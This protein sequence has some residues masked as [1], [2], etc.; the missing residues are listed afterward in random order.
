MFT[1]EG[2]LMDKKRTVIIILFVAIIGILAGIVLWRGFYKN[3]D[4]KYMESANE[5]AVTRYEWMKML[6][7][8][9]G[10][11]EYK[12][13]T[14][15]FSDVN[16]DSVYFPYLQSAVEWGILEIAID[17]D[18][19]NYAS[20]Q[21]AALTAMKTIGHRKLQIYLDTEDVITDDTYIEQAVIHGLIE[22]EQ[23]VEGLSIGECEQILENFKILYFSEFWRDDYTNVQY[24][25]G[26]IELYPGDVLQS[27]ADCSEIVIADKVVNSL[28]VGTIIV[29]EQHNTKLKLARK[30]T[31]IDTDGVLSLIP[32]ELDKVVE[33]ITVSDITELTFE[34]ILNYYGLGENI[35]TV[36]SLKYQQAG[37]G[38]INTAI[39]S[40]E[41]N[42][43]GYK[44]SLSTKGAGKDK[45]LEVQ[46]TDHAT[47]VSVTL[48]ISDK[49]ESDNEYSADVD[50]DRICIGGQVEY[51]LWNGLEYAETAVDAHATFEGMVK[52]D[53]DK[54]I[55][56][57]KTPVPIGNGIVAADIQIY[58][59]LSI[60]GSISFEAELPVEFSIYYEKDKGLR[61]LKHDISIENPTIE[62]NCDLGVMLRLEPTLIILDC[63][64][65]MDIEA[66][67]G[68]TA[69]ANVA[70]H[71]NSQIC[72]DISV[73]FPVITLYVCG[74]DDVDTIIGDM[75]L[76]AEWEIIS[77]ADTPIQLGLHYE[78]LS[79]KTT[80]FV[81]KCT[82]NES[83]ESEEAT[84]EDVA[85]KSTFNNTYYTQ[86]GKV[87]QIDGLVFC[88]DYPNNWNVTHEEVVNIDEEVTYMDYFGEIVELTNNR[89]V[90][91]TYTQ[92][93]M[94][95]SV[96]GN[97]SAFRYTVEYDITKV[98]DSNLKSLN[99]AE[100]EDSDSFMVA[101][102]REYGGTDSNGT[103]TDRDIVSYAVLDQSKEGSGI[104]D[105]VSYQDVCSFYYPKPYS[106]IAIAPDGYFTEE[107]EQEVLAILASFRVSDGELSTTD[108]DREISN[109][110]Q[111][112]AALQKGD[113]SYF[114]GTY[115]PCGIYS[116]W[117]GG[118]EDMN[119]L[120]LQKNGIIVGGG[121][122]YLPD[123]Y[124]ET[125]PISVIKREDDSYLCQ[126][127][128][129]SNDMQKYFLIYPE[130][131][132]GEN[133]YI[134]NDP[135]LTNT[136]YIHYFVFDGKGEEMDVIYYKIE[137]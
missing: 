4:D 137:D 85:D 132:I 134:Y 5:G 32:E 37:E 105:L 119:N 66:D 19:E 73:S 63:L 10:L 11:T 80:Q 112:Y 15:Y 34:D 60:E 46:V 94:S 103:H 111:V 84:G 136:P 47:G 59:I 36:N 96:I 51:S 91:I 113:F 78:I 69:N 56:L 135:L 99:L 101:K 54:K 18:G 45:H 16:K 133:P 88:F 126:V 67:L 8:Q 110:D 95:P 89:G 77:S 40:A 43:K 124:P 17:F 28:E 29:F 131:V 49:V 9:E 98:I 70:T 65:V 38:I 83:E 62:A 127:S 122:W 117:Y 1:N 42:S 39:F 3:K 123:L 128:Y 129:V 14:P 104:T 106:F 92:Y 102:I 6:C 115:K 74:D 76:S 30:I 25:N 100:T 26:V 7:E 121:M 90:S 13:D 64:N 118:G 24:Q 79:D 61:N 55:L 125:K 130:G 57:C 82:Y 21:F 20:G 44:L 87:N 23:L 86:Y 58:L 12:N 52:A 41:V 27:N 33:S 108:E 22:K 53:K 31:G 81:E 2:R 72:A 48:P 93:E 114:S 109:V 71:P 68:V 120:T 107:E 97:G 75:G 35:D 50:I 116:D